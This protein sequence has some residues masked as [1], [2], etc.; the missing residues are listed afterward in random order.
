VGPPPAPRLG[1]PG[2]RPAPAPRAHQEPTPVQ[3]RPP[4][5]WWAAPP[6]TAPPNGAP[7]GWH[8]A[9][10]QPQGHGPR[11]WGA[12]RLARPWGP[13]GSPP[14]SPQRRRRGRQE[15]W[16]RAPRRREGPGGSPPPRCGR[17]TAQARGTQPPMLVPSRWGG[18]PQRPALSAPRSAGRP[19][20]AMAWWRA[21]ARGAW[22]R[23]R[24]RRAGVGRRR[25]WR[26]WAGLGTARFLGAREGSCRPLCSPGMGRRT[27]GPLRREMAKT[28]LGLI[29]F[30]CVVGPP[31]TGTEK[32][33]AFS[34]LVYVLSVEPHSP[35]DASPS[36][37]F[38]LASA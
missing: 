30:P 14:S 29:R 16:G 13:L 31:N 23:S 6:P 20:A 25:R 24:S 8:P 12:G 34:P 15:R 7:D 9:A 1:T 19:R 26:A 10:S 21:A 17:M 38:L 11:R 18:L 3:A 28:C 22:C 37:A 35:Q 2:P 4:A 33:G 5:L 36:S 32:S 27:R